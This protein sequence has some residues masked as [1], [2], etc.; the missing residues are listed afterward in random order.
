[1]RLPTWLGRE[2]DSLQ[3]RELSNEIRKVSRVIKKYISVS[4]ERGEKKQTQNKQKHI[5]SCQQ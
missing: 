5:S 1:M 4:R 3:L 2:S